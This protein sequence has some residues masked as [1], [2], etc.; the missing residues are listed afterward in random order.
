M[1]NLAIVIPAFKK[2]YFDQ[3]IA[4]IANQTCKDFTVYIGDDSSPADLKS[5]VKLYQNQ[6]E[7]KYT[8]F[9]KNVGGTDLVAQWERCIDLVEE[10][11]WIWLFSDDDIMEPNCV[12][13][14]FKTLGHDPNYDLFHFDVLKIDEANNVIENYYSFPEIY[15]SEEFLIGRLIG[16]TSSCVVEYIFRK[17]HFIDNKRFQNFDLAWGSDDAT[18]IK[19]G[20]NNGIK[21]IKDSKVHWR[22]SKYNISPNNLTDNFADRKIHSQIMFAKWAIDQVENDRLEI[23]VQFL[24]KLIHTWLFNSL[25]YKVKFLSLKEVRL[26]FLK[27]NHVLTESKFTFGDFIFVYF[28]KFYCHLKYRIAHVGTQSK[29]GN[30]RMPKQ[31]G[32]SG[33]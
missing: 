5:T 7:I 33:K 27:C 28:Y 22:V 9:A 8:K 11:D 29:I 31:S 24:E 13:S 14:F 6:I 19:L 1:P 16:K 20:K 3:A 26:I 21:T 30:M 15:S 12:E 18:W 10:E 25:R 17:A 23:T 32:I 4:S 2:M